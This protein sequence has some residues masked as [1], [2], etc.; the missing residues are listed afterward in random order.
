MPNAPLAQKIVWMVLIEL[1]GD[2]GEV[3]ACFSLLK[4]VLISKQDRFMLCA[5]RAIGPEISWDE[6]DCTPR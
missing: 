2:E 1:L 4:I 6:P 3:E 5:K